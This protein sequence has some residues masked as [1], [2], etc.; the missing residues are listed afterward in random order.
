MLLSLYKIYLIYCRLSFLFSF[1]EDS[2]LYFFNEKQNLTILNSF[3]DFNIRDQST[4]S[5][6]V[7][8]F[9]YHECGDIL[10]ESNARRIIICAIFLAIYYGGRI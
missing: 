1:K 5:T 8:K 2:S 3:I 7:L 9:T 4:N 6:E 10:R